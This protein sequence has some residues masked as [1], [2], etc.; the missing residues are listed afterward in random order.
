MNL[1]SIKAKL[2]S[3]NVY[4]S[5]QQIQGKPSV[6]GYEKKFKWSWMATQ[7]N[8]FIVATDYGDQQITPAIIEHHL[9]ESYAFSKANYTGWPKGLQSG[10]GVIAIL[11]SSNITPE[12]QEYCVKLK[13]GKKWA[14]FTIP[15]AYNS[16]NSEVYQFAKNPMWGRIYYPHFKK[17]INSLK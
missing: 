14:G 13:S 10:V 12:A 4:H 1:D 3:A 8:T 2:Q 5:D 15:V 9:T 16:S 17:L 6:I 7:M 11:I